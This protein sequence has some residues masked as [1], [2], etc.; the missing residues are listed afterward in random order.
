MFTLGRDVGWGRKRVVRP[1]VSIGL[2]WHPPRVISH[3]W[4]VPGKGLRILLCP[5]S[6]AHVSAPLGAALVCCRPVFR[7]ARLKR[8]SALPYLSALQTAWQGAD[9]ALSQFSGSHLVFPKT[10][11]G[12]SRTG[13]RGYFPGWLLA[14]LF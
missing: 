4:H 1:A 12:F 11:R 6:R 3:P 5:D 10:C 14:E 13:R 2:G 8:P 7:E 9:P